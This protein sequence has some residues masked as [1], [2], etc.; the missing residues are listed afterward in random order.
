[1]SR[2][3]ELKLK[4]TAGKGNL[5]EIFRKLSPSDFSITVLA[6]DDNIKENQPV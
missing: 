6:N 4:I 1:M 3:G 5:F 2:D